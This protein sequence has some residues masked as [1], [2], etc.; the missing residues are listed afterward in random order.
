MEEMAYLDATMIV[1]LDETGNERR[2]NSGYHLR[3]M[4]PT[5]YISF[6]GKHLSTIAIMSTRG[7]EDFDTYDR[8]I[9]GDIFCDFIDRCLI[10]KNLCVAR[11]HTRVRA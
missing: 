8:A 3:G 1:W 11:I 10:M 5:N 6:H 2:R 7:I 4:T 9:N